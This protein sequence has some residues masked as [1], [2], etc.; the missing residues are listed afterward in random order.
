MRDVDDA[1]ALR[2]EPADHLEEEVGLAL[3]E[4]GGRLVEDDDARR[5]RRRAGDGDDLALGDR[6]GFD[7]RLGVERDAEPVEKRAGLAV[8]AAIVDEA[9]AAD[10]LAAEEDVLGDAEIG[11][12]VELLVHRDDAE[13]LGVGRVGDPDRLAGEAD[14]AAVGPVDAGDD[15]HERRLAGTVLAEER[16][17]L[18]GAQIEARPRR[19]PARRESSWRCPRS[20]KS[21]AL[22][23]SYSA[24]SGT[25]FSAASCA[26][27]QRSRNDL[28]STSS[29]SRITSSTGSVGSRLSSVNRCSSV[30]LSRRTRLP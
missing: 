27:V 30:K 10:R 7:D 1:E 4:R 29:N 21:G 19:A 3:G 20:S 17:H 26:L 9:E 16:V 12:E 6:E 8:H 11:L 22:I 18:A 13:G 2:A 14:R 24:G 5:R 25:R 23:S 15:F 28:Y